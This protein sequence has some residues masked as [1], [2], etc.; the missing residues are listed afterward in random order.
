MQTPNIDEILAAGVSF[1]KSYCA[2]PVCGPSRNSIATGR[3]PHETGVRINGDTAPE[4]MPKIGNVFRQ[5]GYNTAW[6][7]RCSEDG[8]ADND[9]DGLTV[10]QVPRSSPDCQTAA[11][12]DGNLADAAIT[13]LESK[14][15]KPFL[16]GVCFENPHDIGFWMM[17]EPGQGPVPDG[18]TSLPANFEADANEPGYISDFRWHNYYGGESVLTNGWNDHQWRRY[19]HAYYRFIENAD[20]SVGRLMK[21]L[22][23]LGLGE[24]TIVVFTSDHGSGNA[25]HRWASSLMLFDEC[26]RVPLSI[27]WKGHIPGGVVNT[28]HLVSSIDI[29]P[30]ICDY[31]GILQTPE[32]TGMSLRGAI[33]NPGTPGR[34]FSVC[35]MYSNPK[36]HLEQGRLIQSKQ[37]AYIVFSKG[38]NREMLFDLEN[39]PGQSRDLSRVSGKKAVL[40]A[41]RKLLRQ[42]HN[43]TD[44]D[45]PYW[46]DF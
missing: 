34:E 20:S 1:E 31:A 5:A 40:E 26:V 10:A 36:D 18:F 15:D 7:G 23:S 22:K 4:S 32:M 44:D 35:E 33:E 16:L 24:D 8:K 14:H 43:Q 6:A 39:D 30:T 42:W 12:I 11:L 38:E 41:H 46:P 28:E 45:F 27:S 21:G 25:A 29:L 13:F 19:L 3:M 2:S 17:K 37:Y 9:I